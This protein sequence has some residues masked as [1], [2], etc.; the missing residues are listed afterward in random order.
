MESNLTTLYV[1]LIPNSQSDIKESFKVT[2]NSNS[3][4]ADLSAEISWYLDARNDGNKIYTIL[5]M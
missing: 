1:H 2:I 5:E 4:I 3:T